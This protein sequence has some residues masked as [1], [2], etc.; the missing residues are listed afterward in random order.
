[1]VIQD[2]P[3]YMD[4]ETVQSGKQFNTN[5]HKQYTKSGPMVDFIVWPALYLCDGGSILSKGV[6]QC[7]SEILQNENVK[8]KS[9]DAG[10]SKELPNKL[11][12]DKH[13]DMTVNPN[14]M[15]AVKPKNNNQSSYESSA[16]KAPP[17]GTRKTSSDVGRQKSSSISQV[18]RTEN[19]KGRNKIEG[20]KKTGRNLN[21]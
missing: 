7:R 1:M 17:K 2:P 10:S 13:T 16:Q 3:V 18:H 15:I 5:T 8:K 21:F 9:D 12:S 19:P 11:D 14:K 20:N 6:A 4:T